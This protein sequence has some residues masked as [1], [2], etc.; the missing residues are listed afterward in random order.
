MTSVPQQAPELNPPPIPSSSHVVIS[1]VDTYKEWHV[2]AVIDTGGSV[3]ATYSFSTTR[4]GYRALIRW[5]RVFGDVHRVGV[6]G[7]GSYGAGLT[8]HLA[9][10]GIEVLKVD[11]P[12]RVDGRR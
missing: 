2:T 3:L 11:R 12:D 1:G 7:T 9:D 10:A 4:A 5:V 6:K 8:R